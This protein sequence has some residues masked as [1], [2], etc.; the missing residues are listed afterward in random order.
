MVWS[1]AEKYVQKN[2]HRLKEDQTC[3]TASIL[4]I[5]P[6]THSVSTNDTL[7]GIQFCCWIQRR[8]YYNSGVMVKVCVNLTG[9]QHPDRRIPHF[10]KV[11]INTI[12]LL[13]KDLHL[14]LEMYIHQWKEIRRGFL[15]LREQGES[16][17]IVFSWPF[18]RQCTPQTVRVAPPCSFT[19]SYTQHLSYKPPRLWSVS[20]SF[21]A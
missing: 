18:P 17:N 7:D 16:E 13:W 3:G 11:H 4:C 9:P 12:S 15:F 10:S 21:C 19:G 8:Q 1:S 6:N 5:A 14:P 2:A 20:M